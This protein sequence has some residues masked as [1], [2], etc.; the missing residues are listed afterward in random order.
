MKQHEASHTG[1]ASTLIYLDIETFAGPKPRL[2]SFTAKANLVDPVKIEKDL[3]EKQEKGWRAQALDSAVGEVYCVGFA[4]ND[5]PPQVIIG[6]DEQETM[7]MFDIELTNHSYPKF[8]A[9]N[10]LEF[11]FPFLLHRGLKHRMKNVVGA[12]CDKT[13]L[14][15]TTHMIAGTSYE[16]KR[17][18]GRV[19]LDKMAQLLLNRKAKTGITGA[20]VHDLVLAGKGEEVIRY[21]AQDVSV[22]RDCYRVL[23]SMGI[24]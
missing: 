18:S 11:D 9:H 22:L 23:T 15:D 12:F 19:S 8:V 24:Y 2:D 21:C 14:I 20:M 10:G 6:V 16:R 13:N 5:D 3:L 7:E 4:V 1:E 17:L